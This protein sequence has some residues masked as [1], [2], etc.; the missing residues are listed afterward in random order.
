MPRDKVNEGSWPSAET[1]GRQQDRTPLK[2]TFQAASKVGVEWAGLL[3]CR[4]EM[5][6]G[7][8]H[9]SAEQGILSPGWYDSATS[10]STCD[11]TTTQQGNDHR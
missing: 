1:E 4:E 9:T 8:S 10:P 5:S 7:T 6:L 11:P 2:N 3:R